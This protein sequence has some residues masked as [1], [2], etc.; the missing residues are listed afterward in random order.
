MSN[1]HKHKILIVEDDTLL[2]ELFIEYLKDE[3]YEIVYVGCGK[4]AIK[5]INDSTPDVILLDLVLPDIHGLEVLKQI[6]PRKPI[7]PVIVVTSQASIK[8]AVEAMQASAFDFIVKPVSAERLVYTVRNALDRRELENKIL[9]YEQP[10]ARE[11]FCGIVGSSAPM[12]AV[13]RGIENAAA[14]DATVFITGGTGTGKELAAE[15]V[16][17]LSARKRKEFVALNCAALPSE[18]LESEIFGHRAGAFTGAI[19]NRK[20]AARQADGGTLF[21]DEVCELAPTLQAKLLRFVQTGTFRMVGSDTLE[22]VDV[23]IVCATN[24][25]PIQEIEAGRFRQD[26]YYRL[27][28]LPI[29]LPP[30]RA[31]AN[32]VVDIAEAFLAATAREEGKRFE[33]FDERSCALLRAYHWPGNVREL[34]NLVRKIVVMH[35]SDVVTADMLPSEIRNGVASPSSKPDNG[36]DLPAASEVF[37]ASPNIQ[38]LWLAE[39]KIIE[40]AITQCGG[41]VLRAAAYLGISD[42]TIYRKRVSWKRKLEGRF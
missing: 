18:L 5:E 16:H 8:L 28:V 6:V 7:S 25:D 9:A 24:R 29:H 27:H 21:L 11:R 12:Q 40:T 35:D 39:K 34:Q 41:N 30:L 19:A 20:G 33:V 36:N 10:V 15:A 2:G 3:P 1:R 38:P 13:Y 17:S 22:S 26:L 31:R 32:D 42:S 23:R 14:S 4:K 37:R